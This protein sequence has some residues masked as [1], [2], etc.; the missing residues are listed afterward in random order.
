MTTVILRERLPGDRRHSRRQ[1]THNTKTRIMKF[2]DIKAGCL[3]HMLDRKNV[4]V[5]HL[6]V[7]GVTPP[8]ADMNVGGVTNL[9]VDI[10]T[11]DGKTYVVLSEAECA[12]PDSKVLATSEN[13]ILNEVRAMETAA[14]QA[15]RQ[16]DSQKEIGRRCRA[17]MLQLDPAE[18]DKKE[19]EA[20]FSNIE[21]KIDRIMD[22]VDKLAN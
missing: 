22:F 4:E 13:L 21:S 2:K 16:V 11:E 15:L 1:T 8:H 20:R 9:V 7:T 18:R 17:L 5:E 3:L 12:Y 14:E 6:K 10:T 19:I